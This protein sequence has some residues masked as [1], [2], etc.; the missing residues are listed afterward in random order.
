MGQMWTHAAKDR[1]PTGLLWSLG[2]A[3]MA[4]LA[5]IW[6]ANSLSAQ[7]AVS[8]GPMLI[9]IRTPVRPMTAI[10][11]GQSFLVYELH[12]TNFVPDRPL[13]IEGVDVFGPAEA[14]LASFDTGQ[15]ARNLRIIG[16]HSSEAETTTLAAGQRAVLFLWVPVSR[17][18]PRSV[19]HRVR[20]HIANVARTYLI[21]DD[22]I[23]VSPR[24]ARVLRP[25]LEGGPWVTANGPD[26]AHV[27]AHNQLLYPER[28]AIH[29]PQRF[30]TD[31]ISIGSNGRAFNGPIGQNSSYG[32]Y[33][34]P[35][36]AVA[37]GTIAAIHDGVPDNHPPDVTANLS[38]ADRPGNYV[39]LNI[40]RGEFAFYGHLKPSSILVKVGQEVAAGQRLASVGNTGNST[41]PHLHFHLTGG[42]SL[43][44]EGLPF[45]FN[46][47]DDLGKLSVS[48]DELVEQ[49]R[50]VAIGKP[51]PKIR[52]LPLGGRMVR[53]ATSQGR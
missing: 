18:S 32:G 20:L 21:D 33:G 26:P 14:R 3:G 6:P 50:P 4:S 27:P 37:N 16:P 8:R 23:A 15:V 30:A 53:F 2:V 41:G 39:I 9:E 10:S 17:Q 45:V 11:G 19:H 48:L 34:V 52:D 46:S 29:M 49:G 44:S 47:Y 51:A 22:P 31:W 25:P 42:P 13:T 28:G 36:L 43:A 7:E 38:Q 1:S 35:V 5:L 24:A 40:G 12:L